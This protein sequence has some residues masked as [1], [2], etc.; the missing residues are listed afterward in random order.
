LEFFV[1]ERVPELT[2]ERLHAAEALWKRVG[3]AS[4]DLDL[5]LG[6]LRPGPV[7]VEVRDGQVSIVT[8]SGRAPSPWT[9]DTWTVP[10]QFET[11]ERELVLAEDPAHQMVAEAGTTLRLRC[12]FDPEFGFPRE[13]RRLVSGAAPPV[14]WSVTRFVA[15]SP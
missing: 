2:L 5:L 1:A 6:G 4:Y 11:I 13:Y 10:G 15:R 14:S 7:H 9:W 3:P 12:E 8:I